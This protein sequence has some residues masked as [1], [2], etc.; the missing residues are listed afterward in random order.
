MSSP[1]VSVVVPSRGGADR[2]P[3]LL[4]A[5]R[6]QR[7]VDWEAVVVLDGDVDGSA[8]VV[9]SV[10]GDLPVRVVTFPENRGR[11]AALNAGFD[12]ARGTVLVRCDDDLVPAPDYL[13]THAAAHADAAVGVVG[14]YRNVYPETTY[15]RVYGRA[16]D[17][18]FRE[19]AYAVPADQ[20]WRYWAGNVS[21]GRVDWERVGPYDEGFRAYGWEDV[22]W[23]YRLQQSGVA[24]TL[25]PA[26]E[27]EHRIAA[28][29]TAM[30]LQRAFYSGAARRRFEAKHG[31]PVGPR[32]PA[33]AWERLVALLA[34][35]LG[36]RSAR[37]LGAAIDAV[38]RVVPA[39]VSSRAVAL[40]IDAAARAGHRTGVTDGAI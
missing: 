2:L 24:I 38:A 5:L 1:L 31:L 9:A 8:D 10:A 19:E 16:W 18:R 4:R 20:A 36:E 34:G 13:A 29:T 3:V 27:T 22:D 28:T 37:A 23:G 11:S 25:V 7:G 17:R 6:A 33:S 14:L 30:R 15:A 26:L 39:A 35:T 32:P 12:A 21:V 40:S